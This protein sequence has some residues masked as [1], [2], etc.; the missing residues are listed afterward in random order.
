[1]GLSDLMKR[2]SFRRHLDAVSGLTLLLAAGFLTVHLASDV[3]KL[4]R[5]GDSTRPEAVNVKV[6]GEPFSPACEPAA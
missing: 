2:P 4:A 6:A 5:N 1:M 3:N